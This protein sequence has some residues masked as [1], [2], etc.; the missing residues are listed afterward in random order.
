MT[1]QL[2]T[3]GKRDIIGK[4]IRDGEDHRLAVFQEIN[5]Q[6]LGEAL[7]F[8]A[9]VAQAKLRGEDLAAEDWYKEEMI[10][11]GKNTD[12]VAA[13]GGVPMKTVENSYGSS[14]RSVVLEAGRDNYEKLL[15]TM[16]ELLEKSEPEVLITI[17]LRGVG[18]DLTVTESLVVV[19]ALAVKRDKIRGGMWSAVG[20]GAEKPLMQVLCE[21]YAVPSDCHRP[22]LP[23]EFTTQTDYV[24][25]GPDRL[26]LVEVKIGGKGNPENAKAAVAHKA[27]LYV[28][29]K[30][31]ETSRDV[32]EESGIEWVE[33]G[34]IQGYRRLGKA[35]AQM[36]IPHTDPPNLD[37]LDDI[38]DEVLPLP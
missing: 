34:A 16:H 8:F 2:T 21:L 24:F 31:G 20:N 6:F 12:D 10:L 11:R 38:L 13:A 3:E 37:R 36:C 32:L 1:I 9:R 7:D 19:N 29:D 17:K 22:A 25:I 28:G 30:I 26:N 5:R 33:L 27:S 18:V 35:L 14:R 4:L 15:T 23:K